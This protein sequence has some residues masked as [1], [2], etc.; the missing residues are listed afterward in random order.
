MP[1]V[2]VN[3]AGALVYYEDSGVPNSSGDYLTLVIVHGFMFHGYGFLKMFPYAASHNLRLVALNLRDYPGSTPYTDSEL[4][5]LCDTNPTNQEIA[6]RLQGL[7]I[8]TFLRHFILANDIP[9]IR[10]LSESK[11][12]GGVAVMSWSLGNVWAVS[13]FGNLEFLDAE[14]KYILQ[15]TL[16]TWVIYDPPHYSFGLPWPKSLYYPLL[17][18]T[19]PPHLRPA[20]F[21]R[22]VS[23]F[24]SPLEKP[25]D[26]LDVL[27]ARVVLYDV[28]NDSAFQP[29]SDVLSADELALM[30]APDIVLRSGRAIF[31]IEEKVW[32]NNAQRALCDSGPSFRHVNALILW[33]DMGPAP[34]PLAVKS[35]MDRIEKASVGGS[36]ARNV[37]LHKIERANHFMPVAPVNNTG[38]VIHYEDSGA[39]EG[40]T[41]YLTLVIIHG[42]IFHGGGFAPLLPHA[43]AHNLRIVALNLRDYPGSTPYTPFELDRLCSEDVKN[44]EIAFREQGLEIATFLKHFIASEHIPPVKETVSGKTGGIAVMSW[45]LGNVWAISM[46]AHTSQLDDETRSILL[47]A[48]RTWILYDPPHYAAGIPLPEEIYFP[49]RDESL[50]P[51][52]RGLAFRRWVSA[53]WSPVAEPTEDADILGSRVILYD[54]TN[55]PALRPTTDCVSPEELDA[56][57]SPDVMLRSGRCLYTT[58]DKVWWDNA[59]KALCDIDGAFSHVNALLIWCEMGPGPCP[60]GTKN[61]MDRVQKASAEG[62]AARHMKV[63]KMNGANHFI[64]W[65]QPEEFIRVLTKHL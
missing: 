64:H 61:F 20:A 43:A 36:A 5:L 42:F 3:K 55:D 49:V 19:M 46:L 45:S 53:F 25:S 12:S 34:C 7:E 59:E 17:D 52:Q 30:S 13:M 48:L 24:W 28:T 18:E 44:Q 23:A 58:Q 1:V 57:S 47:P 27:A 62:R 16:R 50:T 29:T 40:S 11:K 60:L 10:E 9:R 21:T 63:V 51:E 26:D 4:E 41:D 31:T 14:T 33:C 37:T 2:P 65:H 8:A 56:L 35:I 6:V 32:W 38:A 54:V 39:P 15:Q 22:W